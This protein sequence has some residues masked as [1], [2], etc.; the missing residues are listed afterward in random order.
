MPSILPDYWSP[1]GPDQQCHPQ[2]GGC[3]KGVV[4]ISSEM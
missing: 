1:F 2:T 4:P 3:R